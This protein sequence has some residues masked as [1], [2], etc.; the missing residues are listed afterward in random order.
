MAFQPHFNPP[1]RR[2]SS[3]HIPSRGSISKTTRHRAVLAACRRTTAP[4][5]PPL[6]L[7]SHPAAVVAA[8]HLPPAIIF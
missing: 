2:T 7:S 6:P 3:N 1:R 4:L 8:D 5:P